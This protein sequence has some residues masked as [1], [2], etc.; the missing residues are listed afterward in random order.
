MESLL[1]KTSIQQQRVKRLCVYLYTIIWK[2]R[3]SM[4]SSKLDSLIINHK[5]QGIASL[6]TIVYLLPYYILE[7]DTHIRIHDNMNSTMVWY[8]LL[9]ESGHTITLSDVQR[10][11]AINGLPRSTLPSGMDAT[12]WMYLLFKPMT[13]YIINQTLM[14]FVVLFGMYLLL[15]NHVFRT[16]VSPIV[17]AGVALGFAILPFWPPGLLSIAGLPLALHMFLIIR[18]QRKA[19]PIYYWMI[20][21]IYPFFSNFILT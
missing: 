21:A 7:P 15:R 3:T 18:S 5:R 16:K 17:I 20:I 14:R 13:V 9:E 8:K 19:T 6:L 11:N 1:E 2:K 10:P 4:K 12:L